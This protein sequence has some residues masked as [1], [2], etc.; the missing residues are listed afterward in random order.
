MFCRDEYLGVWKISRFAEWRHHRFSCDPVARR[1]SL[2]FRQPPDLDKR[3]A[4][5]CTLTQIVKAGNLSL[6]DP[7][8]Q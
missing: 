8:I 7:N 2:S 3:L 4:A 1:S 5:D 6:H